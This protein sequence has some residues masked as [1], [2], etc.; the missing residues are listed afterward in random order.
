MVRVKPQP[1]PAQRAMTS[2]HGINDL[3]GN[4]IMPRREFSDLGVLALNANRASARNK[5]PSPYTAISIPQ[6]RQQ[7]TAT[8]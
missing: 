1:S 3:S 4:Q 7:V 2:E 8:I 6:N 5:P